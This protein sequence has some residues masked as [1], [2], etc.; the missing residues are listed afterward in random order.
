[1]M[2]RL[3]WLNEWRESDRSCSPLT[4]LSGVPTRESEDFCPSCR[5][6]MSLNPLAPDLCGRG[7]SECENGCLVWGLGGSHQ[8]P[9]LLTC[10]APC[11]CWHCHW[12]ATNKFPGSLWATT[13][14][15]TGQHVYQ[16]RA[17]DVRAKAEYLCS[18]GD[19]VSGDGHPLYTIENGHCS[20]LIT[21]HLKN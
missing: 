20:R 4:V 19:K 14:E 16:G 18:I 21:S 15:F 3:P 10:P 13:Q 8:P 12:W 9:K 17:G 11:Q 2:G 6:P 7:V 5:S 1:M